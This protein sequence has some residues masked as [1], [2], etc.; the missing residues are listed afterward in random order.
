M[1]L[2]LTWTSFERGSAIPLATILGSIHPG[3]TDEAG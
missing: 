3:E 2:P 1:E